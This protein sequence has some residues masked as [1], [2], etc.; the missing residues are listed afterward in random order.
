ME[1]V[2]DPTVMVATDFYSLLETPNPISSFRFL[3]G[4]NS[5]VSR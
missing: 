3:F 1:I 4:G 2:T 5:Q